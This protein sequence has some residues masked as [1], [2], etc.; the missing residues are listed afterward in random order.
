MMIGCHPS[1]K[2]VEFVFEVPEFSKEKLDARTKLVLSPSLYLDWVNDRGNGLCRSKEVSQVL[3][4]LKF[5]PFEY[6]IC[7]ELGKE[8]ITSKEFKE[9]YS[10]LTGMTYFNFQIQVT[11]QSNEFLKYAPT[12]RMSYQE[13]V[14]YCSFQMQNDIKLVVGLDSLPCSMYHFERTYG[15]T[16]YGNFIIG[17][18]E[19]P[20]A[21]EYTFVFS[22]NL[23]ANGI[24]KFSFKRELL[25]N[26]PK[27]KT[28]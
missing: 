28:T 19:L 7:Q 3:Y 6:I 13:R 11:D 15:I 14:M 24:I 5:K 21:P 8:N 26:V 18:Q 16:P 10:E 25:T 2:E 12:N 20:I 1:G 9:N 17:F 22:D 23:F 4:N 27:L